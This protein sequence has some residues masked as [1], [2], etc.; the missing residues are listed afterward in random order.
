DNSQGLVIVHPDVLISATSVADSFTC[1]RKGV[2]NDRVNGNFFYNSALTYGSLFHE[3]IQ[4]CLTNQNFT[5]S[6]M[7]SEAKKLTK[8]S[9]EKLYSADLNEKDV[10][11]EL[12]EEI[13]RIQAWADKFISDIPKPIEEHLSTSRVKPSICIS[14]ILDTEEHIC[15]TTYG[16]KGKIDVSME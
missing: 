16:L 9:I 2:L 11:R 14:K 6:F 8:Q 3:L 5:E 1:M 7:E 4:S 10:I 13:P 12:I 15:S